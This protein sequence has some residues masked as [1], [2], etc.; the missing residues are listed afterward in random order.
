[1]NSAA[2]MGGMSIIPDV[3][4][5]HL[6]CSCFFTNYTYRRYRTLEDRLDI[7]HFSSEVGLGGAASLFTFIHGHACFDCLKT[8]IKNE[9]VTEKII[10]D[11]K[12]IS[13]Y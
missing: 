11:T 2:E 1:M 5:L 8:F 10:W 13:K 4:S 6:I 12:P 7:D 9:V 3:T